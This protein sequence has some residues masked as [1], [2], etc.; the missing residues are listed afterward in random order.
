MPAEGDRLKLLELELPVVFLADVLLNTTDPPA[1]MVPF[2]ICALAI[3]EMA[4]T[5]SVRVKNF[6]IIKFRQRKGIRNR[7]NTASGEL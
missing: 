6:M 5:I 4:E 3:E 2:W 7:N 1:W